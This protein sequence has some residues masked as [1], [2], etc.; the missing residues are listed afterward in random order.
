MAVAVRLPSPDETLLLRAA[1]L[2]APDAA[3]AWQQWRAGATVADSDHRVHALLPLVA[4]ALPDAVLAEDAPVLRGLRRRAWLVREQRRQALLGILDALRA[5]GLP[6]T[7]IGATPWLLD[8]GPLAR[9]RPVAQLEA[10]VP[11]ASWPDAIA[12]LAAR[13]WGAEQPP[14]PLSSRLRLVASGADPLVL[15]WGRAFPRL[16]RSVPGAP[17]PGSAL[18]DVLL[19]GQDEGPEQPLLWPVHAVLAVGDQGHDDA[20]WEEACTVADAYGQS[21]TTGALLGWLRDQLGLAV[22]ESAARRLEHG[23]QDPRLARERGRAAATGRSP[24]RWRRRSDMA[25]ARARGDVPADWPALRL[26]APQRG[27]GPARP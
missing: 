8:D 21:G 16:S 10:W 3:A 19:A 12:A 17:T 5:P 11:A 7:P 18:V 1:L 22:P 27:S 25:A 6:V 14:W 15:T 23:R 13:G 4:A 26:R 9:E 2:D 20:F 24:S